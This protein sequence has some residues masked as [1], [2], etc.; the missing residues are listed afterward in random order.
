ML[1]YLVAHPSQRRRGELARALTAKSIKVRLASDGHRALAMAIA[2]P[3]DLVLAGMGLDGLDA[4]KLA[5][6]MLARGDLARVPILVLCS[7]EE[8]EARVSALRLGVDDVM[9]EPVLIEEIELR[10]RRVMQRP[11]QRPSSLSAGLRGTLGQFAVPS[12]LG[13]LELDRKS[14]ILKVTCEDGREAAVALR[15]GEVVAAEL[16]H[17][18]VVGA[19]VIYELARWTTGSFS[20][21]ETAVVIRNTIGVSVPALI[22]EAARRIDEGL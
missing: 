9:V 14:G 13:L 6:L 8:A 3:P 12:V 4:I 22:L 1:T 7:A 16:L 21:K 2:S 17:T 5:R 19:E 11:K 15:D 20:F 10:A 18:P